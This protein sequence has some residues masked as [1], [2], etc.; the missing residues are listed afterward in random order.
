MRM[1]GLWGSSMASSRGLLATW[2]PLAACDVPEPTA[3]FV[4]RSANAWRQ[5]ADGCGI[6]RENGKCFAGWT[7]TGTRTGTVRLVS[8]SRRHP[9]GRDSESASDRADRNSET[10]AAYFRSRL[11]SHF[12]VPFIT[13]QPVPFSWF[14]VLRALDVQ[15]ERI[16]GPSSAAGTLNDQGD[17]ILAA[18]VSHGSTDNGRRSG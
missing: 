6:N 8:A 3:M 17:P 10:S 11:Q 14:A 7:G 4:S 16:T 9:S 13:C 2:V 5:D 1:P 15:I 18:R 12:L